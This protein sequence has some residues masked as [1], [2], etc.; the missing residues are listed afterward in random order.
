MTRRRYAKMVTGYPGRINTWRHATLVKDALEKG[1]AEHAKTNLSVHFDGTHKLLWTFRG[2]QRRATGVLTVRHYGT[3]IFAY[4]FS[5]DLM[6]DFGM[7]GH[8][9]T[10]TLNVGNFWRALQEARFVG[11]QSLVGELHGLD[12]TRTENYKLRGAGYHEEMWQRFR[13]GVPWTKNVDG[14]WWFHGPSFSHAVA[15]EFDAG[16]SKIHQN[17][18]GNGFGEPLWRWFTYDW[19]ANGAWSMRFIDDAA[20][21]RWE[22]RQAKR[23]G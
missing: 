5:R 19:D 12:W 3:R 21:A 10:T 9:P 1:T 23:T 18:N 20:K 4:D 15:A 11:I 22:K 6:T 17:M 13:A 14:A 2:P 7:R 8:S 16:R